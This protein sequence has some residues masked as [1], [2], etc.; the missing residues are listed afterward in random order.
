MRLNF[1]LNQIGRRR[2]GIRLIAAVIGMIA[3]ADVTCAQGTNARL[4]LPVMTQV[5]VS[6]SQPRIELWNQL[7]TREKNL[8]YH[9]QKAALA[10]RSIL[11]EQ[12]H[13]YGLLIRDFF[14]FLSDSQRIQNVRH[15]LGSRA[16]DELL[17]Y[18]AKFH[19]LAGPYSP[20]NRK[21]VL[22][23][24]RPEQVRHLLGMYLRQIQNV[25]L[26]AAQK[27]E[28]VRLLTD[29]TYE[30]LRQPEESTDELSSTGGNLYEKGITSAQV[31]AALQAGLTSDLNC[32]IVRAETV[33]STSRGGLDC[34]R[35]TVRTPGVVGQSLRNV[36][37]ELRRARP[38][39]SSD[40]QGREIDAFIRYFETGNVADFRQANI[41]W[42]E[43]RTN[44]KVDFM[45]GFVEVYED[46]MG[47][48]GSWESYVQIV[49]P[50][51]TRISQNLARSAQYFEDQ[52]PYGQWRKHFPADYAPPALMV[53]YF[54]E[55][56]SMRSGGYN[57][58]NFDDIRRDVGF[59]NVIRLDLPGQ[60][61]DPQNRAMYEQAYRAFM[62]TDLV[63]SALQRRDL[64]WRVMVLL[65]EIIG[66]GSGTYDVTRY[67][68][69]EDPISA[70]GAAGGSA[71][72]EQRADLTALV[73]ASDSRLVEAGI[74]RDLVEAQATRH[75]MYDIY[76][77]SFLLRFSKERSLSESHSRGHWL[78]I[79]R[80]IDAGAV[81]WEGD[82]AHR[83]LRV[84][85]YDRFQNVSRDLL[86]ELQR[87]KA[88]R[89]EEA[90][91][92]LLAQDAPLAAANQDWAQSAIARGAGLAYNAGV[93]EQPWQITRQLRL[94][95]LGNPTLLGASSHW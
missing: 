37:A 33:T 68:P 31:Q 47:R 13:R 42:V 22:S 83:V 67:G 9:L 53:Y 57:L 44:S 87:I 86:A 62:P 56:A 50:L 77:A 80:L 74:Y 7:S 32:K 93:V 66:H 23:V 41:E 69:Q 15:L 3:S 63:E 46:Y 38:F 81:A 72:E 51:T 16:H 12:N 61:E 24:V 43:D 91:R 95:T 79:K 17:A 29:S 14:R 21:Y 82:L 78:L 54:Q 40:H 58:P 8:A 76:L 4:P 92:N 11:F 48:I 27:E 65:H 45:L 30:V 18:A 35:Q 88:T 20:S 5:R 49:D 36:V 59:K 84:V 90:L 39:A 85:D 89:D 19:D 28:I 6:S 26:S 1:R 64:Q 55:I 2:G 25:R 34:Q 10:G 73:F 70:L 52:M 60:A 94:R 71:L 75:S